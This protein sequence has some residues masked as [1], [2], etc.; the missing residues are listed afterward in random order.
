[1]HCFRAPPGRGPA[2]ADRIVILTMVAV[3]VLGV[4]ALLLLWTVILRRSG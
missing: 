3:T 2:P 1:L 4:T